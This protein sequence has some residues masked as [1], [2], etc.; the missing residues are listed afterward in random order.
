M[1]LAILEQFIERDK[2]DSS[3]TMMH[4]DSVEI[5]T[6]NLTIEEEIE[7]V[8]GLAKEII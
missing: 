3:F 6:T 8:V 4:E 2:R 1:H 7:K 5:D